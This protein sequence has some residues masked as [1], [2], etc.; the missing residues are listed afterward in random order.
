M[1][2]KSKQTNESCE[3][4]HRER[5]ES[6]VMTLP[7][8]FD[9]LAT[10]FSP[11]INSYASDMSS[12][13]RIGFGG[14]SGLDLKGSALWSAKVAGMDSSVLRSRRSHSRPATDWAVFR[15]DSKDELGLKVLNV[16]PIKNN[17]GEGILDADS[18]IG[19]ED[20][21]SLNTSVNSEAQE[22]HDCCEGNVCPCGV[23]AI[24]ECCVEHAGAE[25]VTKNC[26]DECASSA[27][28][29][30]VTAILKKSSIGVIAHE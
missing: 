25:D 3:S 12:G 24:G 7:S 18:K 23:I 16:V 13:S 14:V 28:D 26:V 30:G 19:K 20:A 9:A 21:W 10:E 29:L 22:N 11:L 6:R 4:T 1:K 2:L 17:C 27:K 15:V 5:D 8:V